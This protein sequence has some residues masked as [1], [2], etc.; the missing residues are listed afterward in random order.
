MIRSQCTVEREQIINC[1][2][3]G[4][5]YIVGHSCLL[6]Y[7]ALFKHVCGSAALDS[8]TDT[9]SLEKIFRRAHIITV[10]SQYVNFSPNVQILTLCVL[11]FFIS[12]TVYHVDLIGEHPHL[13]LLNF[14]NDIAF[15]QY[16]WQ[17]FF[18]HLHVFNFLSDTRFL[19]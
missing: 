16:I 9:I 11:N 8:H 7:T 1:I 18:Y 15:I 14:L 13:H 3:F 10:S 17:L 12:S 2:T 4:L 6:G 5:I 19:Q